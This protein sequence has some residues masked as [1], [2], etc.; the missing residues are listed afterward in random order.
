MCFASQGGGGLFNTVQTN[1]VVEAWSRVLTLQ[2]QLFA[3]DE[4]RALT[5]LGFFQTTGGLLDLG[6]GEG[7]FTRAIRT[8]HPSVAIVAAEAN[9]SLL[10]AF[11]KRLLE[12]PDDI[13][14]VVSWYAGVEP[15]PVEVRGCRMALLR[16]VLQHVENPR[17]LLHEIGNVLGPGGQIGVIEEDDG[18]FQI[19]PELPAFLRVVALWKAYVDEHDGERYM[20]RRIPRLAE[21]AGLRIRA[22]KVVVHTNINLGIFRLMEYFGATLQLIAASS[23]G[24]LSME[25]AQQLIHELDV[26]ARDA[27]RRCFVGYPQIITLIDVPGA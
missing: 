9:A 26:F 18:F 5:D 3:E 17:E 19:E 10:Q 25:E 4:L 22:L 7:S 6:C 11:R 21:E 12:E 2:T 8:Y 16:L 27:G 15:P 1:T 14:T 20:G 24:I 13:T 23:P